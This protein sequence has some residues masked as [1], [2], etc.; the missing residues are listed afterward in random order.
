[1]IKSKVFAISIQYIGPLADTWSLGVILFAMVCGY[2]PFEGNNTSILYKKILT[3]DYKLP[4]FISPVRS[5]QYTNV[6]YAFL[7]LYLPIKFNFFLNQMVQDLIKKILETNPEKRWTI[8]KIR[9]HPWFNSVRLSLPKVY[10]HS[11]IYI[12]TEREYTYITCLSFCL[13]RCC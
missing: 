4:N 9:Q 13:V 7:V 1:M 11:Y 10:I 8:E 2:L 5:L 6:L 12:L 3:A